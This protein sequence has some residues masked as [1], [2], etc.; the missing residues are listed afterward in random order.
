MSVMVR[1]IVKLMITHDYSLTQSL[2]LMVRISN[3]HSQSNQ[4]F[5]TVESKGNW[6]TRHSATD[7][8]AAV[9]CCLHVPN[10]LLFQWHNEL[11]KDSQGCYIERLN[12]AIVAK[13]LTVD[14]ECERLERRLARQAGTIQS[15][16]DEATE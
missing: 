3:N 1:I 15:R 9:V 7:D 8:R 12:N 6:S 4:L 14:R 5:V 2:S 10:K 13:I 11:R 16:T